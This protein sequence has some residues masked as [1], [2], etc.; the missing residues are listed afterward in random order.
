MNKFVQRFAALS[1]QQVL[2]V[3]IILGG[4]YYMMAFDDGSALR[5]QNEAA[6]L[7]IQKELEK[8][9]DTDATLTEETQ[10]KAAVGVLSQQYTE[11][12][13]RLP[14]TLSPIE[15]NRNIDVFARNSGVS[16]KSR[17]PLPLIPGEIVEAVPVEVTLEGGFS[18]LA[19]FLY[20]TALSER[21]SGFASYSVS[22]IDAKSARLKLEGVIVGY[23]LAAEKA[24]AKGGKAVTK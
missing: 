22:T 13:R 18:E 11:V 23:Q 15:L 14:S 17:K 21:A 7:E 16:I 4:A 24:A 6:R 5:A 1:F 12:A 20:L 2:I 3:G 10:M 8:K 9:R 19:Q